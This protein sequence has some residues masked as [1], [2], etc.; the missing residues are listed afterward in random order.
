MA[1]RHT[2]Y[3]CCIHQSLIKQYKLVD[4]RHSKMPSTV[5]ALAL[6][7]KLVGRSKKKWSL[8]LSRSADMAIQVAWAPALTYSKRDG[9]LSN[10]FLHIQP[11]KVALAVRFAFCFH[12]PLTNLITS[13]Q[14]IKVIILLCKSAAKVGW[15]NLCDLHITIKDLQKHTVKFTGEHVQSFPGSTLESNSMP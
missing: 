2:P 6:C 1:G 9:Q 7:S 5:I 4:I 13:S 3:K 10:M 15:L 11:H 12:F 14:D 8:S